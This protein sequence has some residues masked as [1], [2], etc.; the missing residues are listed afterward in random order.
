MEVLWAHDGPVSVRA[1]HAALDDRGLAYTTVMTVL[2]RLANKNV[3]KR[4]RQGRAWL[5]EPAAGREAY[6]AD[7]M[8]EALE[9]SGDRGS[10]LVHFAK[11]VSSDEADALTRALDH[12]HRRAEGGAGF[13]GDRAV[14]PPHPPQEPE[15]PQESQPP[16]GQR[17]EHS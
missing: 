15:A 13:P 2:T 14:P 16:H 17:G 8:L 12:A 5:Y 9:L 11:S 3:V 10:A 1:V 7:L 4:T 6:V